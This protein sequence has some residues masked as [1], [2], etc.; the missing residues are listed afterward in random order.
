MLAY[1]AADYFAKGSWKKQE[2]AV[3]LNTKAPDAPPFRLVKSETS[4]EEFV[5]IWVKAP[6]GQAVPNIDVLMKA[7]DEAKKSRTSSDGAAL[8]PPAGKVREV[9]FSTPV[10]NLEAGPF[11]L[12]PGRN[13]YYFE[14]NGE[15]ITTVRF[16]DEKLSI[17]GRNLVM[18]YWGAE[19][20]MTYERQG[21][22]EAER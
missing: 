19:H 13:E 2:G 15:A 22:G 21:N 5:R 7:D 4:P 9:R 17:D 3:V 18:R 6:N 1:G 14:I 12:D 16:R 8:F 20:P 11:P 10:Y